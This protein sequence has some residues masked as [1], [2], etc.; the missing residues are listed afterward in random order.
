VIR[1]RRPITL[2]Y[3]GLPSI[4]APERSYCPMELLRRARLRDASQENVEIA[5]AAVDA[6][7]RGDVDAAF[8]VQPSGLVGKR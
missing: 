2:D 5:R 7:N 1:A 6:V 3:R 8:G 4:W